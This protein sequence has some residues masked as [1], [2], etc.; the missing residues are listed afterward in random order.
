[1]YESFNRLWRSIYT[2]TKMAENGNI[3]L[4]LRLSFIRERCQEW[5][6]PQAFEPWLQHVEF[7]AF[8]SV[9]RNRKCIE[10]QLINL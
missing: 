8:V 5:L 9:Y 7:T 4:H 3:L 10:A 2:T 1:M 6:N